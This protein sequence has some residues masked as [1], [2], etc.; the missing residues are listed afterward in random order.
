MSEAAAGTDGVVHPM[1]ADITKED[2]LDRV[3]QWVD[4]HL[5]AIAAIVNNAG[6]APMKQFLGGFGVLLSRWAWL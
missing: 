4:E 5:G 2:D 1:Q 6:I 3:F